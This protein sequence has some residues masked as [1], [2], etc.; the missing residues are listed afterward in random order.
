VK[1]AMEVAGRSTERE[2]WS[3]VYSDEEDETDL[4]KKAPRD[5]KRMEPS[6]DPK[7]GVL[8]FILAFAHRIFYHIDL[9]DM[10][11]VSDQSLL[12]S[13]LRW[14]D[15]TPQL[16]AAA[17][18]GLYSG[19]LYNIGQSVIRPILVHKLSSDYHSLTVGGYSWS[20]NLQT[21]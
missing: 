13:D 7:L 8:N 12:D 20:E 5:L 19:L 14:I 3:M 6:R 21:P 11:A 2:R 16:L 1:E 15:P 4:D 17:S 18:S 9:L 10:T